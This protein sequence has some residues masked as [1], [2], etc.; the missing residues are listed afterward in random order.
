MDILFVT[1]YYEPS[2]GAAATRLSDLA[3]RLQKQGH[4]VTVITGMPHYPQGRIED[5]YR[6]QIARVEMRDGVHVIYTWLW[7]TNSPRISRK[8][9]S[10][11]SLMVSALLRGVSLPRPDVTFI[12]AQPIFTGLAGRM[13]SRLKGAPY[14][15]NVS[16][17]WPDHLL[18]VGA[19]QET[20]LIYRTARAV[21]DSGYRNAAAITTLSPAWTE[22]IIG[23]LNH[24]D[25][26]R[27]KTHTILRGVDVERFRPLPADN[28]QQLP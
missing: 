25:S 14:V 16:D 26:A 24:T 10:Q 7:T 3:R 15:L 27:D 11:L 23:Y 17:L 13:I 2:G 19:L 18:S 9:I 5:A 20:D 4:R 22:T 21:V 1:H 8:L 6:G 12:E 28:V